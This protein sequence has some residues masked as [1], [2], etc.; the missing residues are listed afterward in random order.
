MKYI[1]NKILLLL[2][3]SI[4]VVSCTDNSELSILNASA[5]TGAA[6]FSETDLI[7]SQS[8]ENELALTI[9]FQEPDF[10]YNAGS[11]GY[12]LLFDLET[13]FDAPEIIDGGTSF[14]VDLTH[15]ELNKILLNLGAEPDVAIQ[16]SVK[17]ETVLS[18]DTSLFSEISALTVTPYSADLDLTSRWGLVGSATV[19]GWNGPDMPFYKSTDGSLESGT[20]VAY[21]TL[22]DGAIKIR[23]DNDWTINYGDN[24]LDNI[25]EAGGTDIAIT[26]GTYKIIFNENSLTYSVEAYSWGLVGSATP[27]GWDGPDVQFNYNPLKDN[28]NTEA[29]LV[30]GAIKIRFN[31]EWVTAYGDAEPDGILDTSANNDINVSAG[32]YFITFSPET[33]EYSIEGL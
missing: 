15:A 5:S 31:N 11:I 17:I 26:A 19:N 7:L 33:L 12:Q 6:V 24:E 16:L 21:V 1:L 13:N 18:T 20:F 8:N 3:I 28:W 10:G 30:D 4:I 23:A 22:I 2:G 32:N 25:L 27:N 29:T 14:A 9:S